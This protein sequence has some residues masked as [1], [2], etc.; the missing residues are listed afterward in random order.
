[1]ITAIVSVITAVISM[2]T[3]LI[4]SSEAS[5]AAGDTLRTQRLMHHTESRDNK[6]RVAPIIIVFAVIVIVTLIIKTKS[7][8]S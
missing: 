2:L 1:M 7:H 4:K 3:T 5:L 6:E 8:A